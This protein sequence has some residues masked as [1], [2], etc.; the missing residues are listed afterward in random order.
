[1]ASKVN[2]NSWAAERLLALGEDLEPGPEIPLTEATDELL[3]SPPENIKRMTEDIIGLNILEIN[4]LMKAIQ[5]CREIQL[6][7]LFYR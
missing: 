3:L 4:Q 1:M 2:T 7:L 5:V 6:V